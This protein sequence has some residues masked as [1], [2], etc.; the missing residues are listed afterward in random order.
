MG[1]IPLLQSCIHLHF[2]TIYK[3]TY[4][5]TNELSYTS[6]SLPFDEFF[7][8]LN[9]Q[10]DQLPGLHLYYEG[11]KFKCVVPEIIHT[12]P[13]EGIFSNTSPPL[14]KFQL[15]F[16]HFFKFFGLPE[17]PTPQEIPIPSVGGVWIFSETA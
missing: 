15:S 2:F 1:Y 7:K 16:I 12:S 3:Y 17:P 11:H 14:W 6:V 9:S 5:F 8:S 10:H 4:T 13:T